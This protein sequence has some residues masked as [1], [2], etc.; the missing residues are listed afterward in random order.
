[1]SVVSYQSGT[2]LVWPT[3]YVNRIIC[4]DCLEVM[5]GIPDGAVDLVCT[6]PPYFIPANHYVKTRTATTPNRTLA[7]TSVLRTYFALFFNELARV[8][9]LA[10]TWYVFC[11]GQSYPIFYEAMFPFCKYVRPLIWDKRVSYNGYTWRHQHELIAWG[12]RDEAE[13]V[14]TGDGDILSYRGV[15]QEKRRHPAEKPVKLM[16]RLIAKHDDGIVLDPFCGSAPVA[17]SS[18]QLGRRYIGIEINPDY[19]KI[20]EDRLRQEELF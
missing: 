5:K 18:Q 1:M 2:P 4:G 12:E 17:E 14:P 10:A 3:D 15:P 8:T 20:A 19:C 13:R 7:D 9:S 11:D 16:S 6:D